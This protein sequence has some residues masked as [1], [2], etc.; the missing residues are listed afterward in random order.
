MTGRLQDQ[1]VVVVGGAGLLGRQFCLAAAEA[2]ATVVVADR[3]IAQANALAAE[4]AGLGHKAS[5]SALDITDAGGID[6][7]IAEVAG[8]HG[9][10]AAVVNTA[11]PRGPNYGRRLEDVAYADFCRSVDL[12]LGGYFLV[13]QRFALHFR[14][15]GSGGSI[16]NLGSIYGS[17]NPRHEVYAG[18]PMTMPVEYAAIKSAI[19][20]MTRYFAHYFK[21]DGIRANVLSPGGIS[22][23]QPES[24]IKAYSSFCGRK[25]ML[26][27]RDVSG[28]LVFLLSDES[29]FITGQN[30]VVDDGFSL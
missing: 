16:V 1:V 30:L 5:A 9:T 27:P 4:L 21:A 7:T 18:T 2:G 14:A 19:I 11:Y 12:H 17:M 8:K 3:D 6:A 15:Q 22:D 24:F 28:A 13:A 20:Q 23:R 25:G 26:D 29:R 10:I